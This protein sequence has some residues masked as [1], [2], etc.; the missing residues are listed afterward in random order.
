MTTPGLW[1]A[2][3]HLA[4]TQEADAFRER[5]EALVEGPYLELF[6]RTTRPGWVSWGN[7]VERFEGEQDD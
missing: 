4:D 6:A 7:E 5:M 2:P 1:E 3:P